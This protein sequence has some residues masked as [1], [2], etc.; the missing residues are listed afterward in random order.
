MLNQE[1]KLNLLSSLFIASL[2]SANL[3]GIKIFSFFHFSLSVG[4]LVYPLTFLITDAIGE[5]YGYKKAKNLIY[6][7]F[8]AQLFVFVL[9]VIAIKLPNADRFTLNNEY[10]QIFS[11]SLRMIIASLIAFLISQTHDIW[12][13]NWWKQKTNGH[14]LWLRNNASTIISQA[15]DTLIFMFIAF[16]HLTPKFTVIFILELSLNYWLFKILFALLDTPFLYGLVKW[17]KT[18]KNKN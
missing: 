7:A 11:S 3:L 12:S 13:F 1:F 10:Q 15:I 17:L 18:T 5:V 2:I 9:I 8:L 6:S 4:I 16:Y 14:Y